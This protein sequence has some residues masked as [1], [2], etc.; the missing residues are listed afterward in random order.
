MKQIW[1][2]FIVALLVVGLM[3]LAWSQAEQRAPRQRGDWG[4][5]AE[6]GQ[7]VD[8]GGMTGGLPPGAYIRTSEASKEIW[9][10]IGELQIGIHQMTWELSE[11]R[12]GD[13]DQ[14]QVRE[15]MREIRELNMQMREAR[16]RLQDH[17]VM[18]EGMLRE[19]RQ[20]REGGPRGDAEE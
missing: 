18:P 15:K 16:Q 19:I 7:R 6:R 11:L 14:D 9:D 4:E 8:R 12:S 10:Q 20:R 2:W 5:R 17:I 3:A 13:A 1:T